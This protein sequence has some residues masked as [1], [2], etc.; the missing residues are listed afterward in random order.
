MRAFKIMCECRTIEAT[1]Q[2]FLSFFRMQSKR[3]QLWTSLCKFSLRSFMIAYRSS[4]KHFKEQFFQLV[5]RPNYLYLL[6][7]ENGEDL[8]PLSWT[9]DPR[10]MFGFERRDLSAGDSLE[11]DCLWSVVQSRDLT[12]A[13]TL[14]SMVDE[15][16]ELIGYL[17]NFSFRIFPFSYLLTYCHS[18]LLIFSS[19]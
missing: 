1:A 12:R 8:F 19:F 3:Q 4:Y 10:R 14:I 6:V 2:K 11:V 18:A 15:P 5:A 9:R 17:R 16:E 7:A 13:S